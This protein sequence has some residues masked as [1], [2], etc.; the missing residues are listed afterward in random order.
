MKN[1]NSPI[2]LPNQTI[3]T[4]STSSEPLSLQRRQLIKGLAIAPLA[5]STGMMVTPTLAKGLSWSDVRYIL[6]LN[7]V[8]F[9]A[10]L[11]FDVLEVVVVNYIER[12]LDGS[13]SQYAGLPN[14]KNNFQHAK[15]KKA[16]V[17]I[18]PVR[19]G[20]SDEEYEAYREQ[21][22]VQ[23][24]RDEDNARFET[25]HKHLMDTKTRIAKVGD[26]SS[27]VIDGK[28]IADDLFDVKY[29]VFRDENA[30][31]HYNE[32]LQKTEVTVFEKMVV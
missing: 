15:Y 12:R 18:H 16:V 29:L 4:I 6:K 10:G 24:S 5:M 19:Y 7:F 14:D 32:L 9:I 31:R 30:E 28:L 21:T 8:R 17:Q 23:P 3:S 20:M 11:I 13:Y 2:I 25:I 1:Q 27:R 22:H 26:N